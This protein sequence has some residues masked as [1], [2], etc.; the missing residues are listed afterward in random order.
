M[1][2]KMEVGK[3]LLALEH[4]MMQKVNVLS[5]Q[6]VNMYYL[7]LLKRICIVRLRSKDA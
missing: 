5:M 6:K 2:K 1:M 3:K 4:I 7:A